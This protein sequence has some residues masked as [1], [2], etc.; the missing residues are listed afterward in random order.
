MFIKDVR[1][2]INYHA[3]G[4]VVLYLALAMGWI[5][6]IDYFLTFARA[7]KARSK[8]QAEKTEPLP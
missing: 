7:V 3:V 6:G 1:L 8:A 4:I 5:S 2:V